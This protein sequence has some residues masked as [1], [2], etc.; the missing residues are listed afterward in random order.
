MWSDPRLTYLQDVYNITREKFGHFIFRAASG[1]IAQERSVRGKM[2]PIWNLKYQSDCP[3]GARLYDVAKQKGW[4]PKRDVDW[5]KRLPRTE[6]AVNEDSFLALNIGIDHLLDE[7]TL[8]ELS[9]V[10]IEWTMSQI[11]HGEQG[12]LMLASQLVNHHRDMDG[13]LFLASQAMDEARHIE[14]FSR[15][16]EPGRIHDIDFGVKFVIDAFLSTDNWR[17]QAIGMLVLVEGYALGTFA[18]TKEITRDPLLV[19]ML[20]FV[21]RDEG[22]HVGFGLDAIKGSVEELDEQ[23]RQEVEDFAFA[24]VRSVAFTRNSGGGFRDLIKMYWQH[25][26]P[27]VRKELTYKELEEKMITSDLMQS[28]NEIV[29]NENL[30]P[31]LGRLGMMTDRVRPKYEEMGLDV[32]S[33]YH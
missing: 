25:L 28:F 19:D 12:A 32:S 15:Y 29:F 22:R 2:E 17:K 21:M 23:D 24:L 5:S 18:V 31:N 6:L 13:K 4:D 33:Y 11:L 20:K 26:G 16:L 30:L 8:I 3:R 14:V 1:G 9:H 10:E 27:R 7:E